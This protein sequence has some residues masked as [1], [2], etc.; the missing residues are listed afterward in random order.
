V[1]LWGAL[2]CSPVRIDKEKKGSN[3]LKQGL[4]VRMTIAGHAGVTSKHCEVLLGFIQVKGRSKMSH[5]KDVLQ[6]NDAG[7]CRSSLTGAAL[8]TALAHLLCFWEASNAANS[9]SR[10]L[11]MVFKTNDTS[12]VDLQDAARS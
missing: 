8:R 10:Q 12:T 7:Y 4:A 1:R 5:L 3:K 2:N 9:H 11:L 6:A